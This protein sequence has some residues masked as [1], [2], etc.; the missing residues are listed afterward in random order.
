MYG[1][2]CARDAVIGCVSGGDVKYTTNWH[3]CSAESLCAVFSS[4]EIIA[5]VH[6]TD[7][8]VTECFVFSFS[9]KEGLRCT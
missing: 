2:R 8:L 6:R 4:W 9:A 3:H 1:V 5:T 7:F